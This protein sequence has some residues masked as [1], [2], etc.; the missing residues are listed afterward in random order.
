MSL[1]RFTLQVPRPLTK[2]LTTFQYQH[3]IVVFPSHTGTLH[4]TGKPNL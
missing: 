2:T 3:N 4:I 1:D